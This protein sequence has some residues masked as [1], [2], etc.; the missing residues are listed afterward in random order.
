MPVSLNVGKSAGDDVGMWDCFAVGSCVGNWVDRGDNEMVV[1]A[2][3][4]EEVPKLAI[5][6]LEVHPARSSSLNYGSSAVAELQ[7]VPSCGS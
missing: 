1:G 4:N 6:S 2:G 5:Q 7:A 3:M